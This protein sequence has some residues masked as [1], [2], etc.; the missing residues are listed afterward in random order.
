MAFGIVTLR[1]RNL[2]LETAKEARKLAMVVEN[3]FNAVAIADFG[4]TN[5]L[6]YV[7][8]SWEHMLGY[9][10]EE[11]VNKK[12]APA[13]EA[14]KRYPEV[15][16]EF[17]KCIEDGK[18]FSGELEMQRKNGTFF[19]I[20]ANIIPLKDEAGNVYTWC[21]VFRDI[22]NE[23]A[24]DR[25]KSE[26]VSLASHQLRTPL[27]GIKWLSEIVM[28]DPANVFT[29]SGRE[30]M[31]GIVMSNERMISLV[32]DLLDVSHLETGVNYNLVLKPTDVIPL[33]QGA[34][35][36]V[37]H[38]AS[39]NNVTVVS[40]AHAPRELILNI[41]G[42]KIQQVLEN[43]IGN[44]IKYSKPNTN[45]VVKVIQESDRAVFSVADRGI[46]IPSEQQTL[47]FTRFFRANNAS[48]VDISGTG[49][50]LY[51]VKGIIETHHGKV[52]FESKEG[53]GST[54]YFSLP[55]GASAL[56]S[57]SV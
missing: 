51:I 52:W 12:L 49:L 42:G 24:V 39:K 7:N 27:T 50:G 20:A 44:A 35:T 25:M 5:T 13:L 30:A 9:T 18:T 2:Q 4:K 22:T 33:I 57:R 21:N 3:T 1:R 34:I 37:K 40:D 55:M 36:D 32:N 43:L 41:D 15:E 48:K 56:I 38:L 16:K 45:V 29:K 31:D 19:W 23:K 28:S 6:L 8:P 47:V 26:F 53:E 11:V 10:K 14:I 46:G 54:F 17:W